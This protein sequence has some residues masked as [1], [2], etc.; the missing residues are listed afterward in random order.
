M[1]DVTQA[2]TLLTD[3]GPEA[4]L[5]DKAYDAAALLL[6]IALKHAKAVI[7]PKRN[8]KLQRAFDGHQYRNRKS[9]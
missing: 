8:R 7:L 2:E 1:H 4:V 3:I 9:H 6:Y 5:A